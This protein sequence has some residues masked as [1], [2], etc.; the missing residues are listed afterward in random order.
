MSGA[1]AYIG[2]H[3]EDCGVGTRTLGEYYAVKDY[4]WDYA[5]G[6]RRKPWH[7]SSGQEILCIGCLENRIGRTLVA[8]DFIPDV[9]ANDPNQD[10]ISERMRD[11]L[12]PVRRDRGGAR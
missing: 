10:D 12:R 11:R 3:C 7:G 2:L 5:W 8:S 9:P 6:G 4:V 1:R